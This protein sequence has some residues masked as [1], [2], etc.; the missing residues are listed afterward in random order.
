MIDANPRAVAGSNMP[1]A[2]DAFSMALDDVYGEAKN[3]L[4]GAA[5]ENQAQADA[6]GVIMATARRIRRDADTA[7]AAE[8]QPFDLASKAVQE[9]WRPLLTRADNIVTAAQKPL[10]AF[11]EAEQARQREAAEAARAEVL[12]LQQEAN[13]ARQASA[14]NLAAVEQAEALQKDADRAVKAAGRAEKVKPNVAGMDR[15]VGLRSRQIATVTDHRALLEH[16]MKT[17]PAPLKAWLDEYARKA[18]PS[19]L[20]GVTISNER[21]AA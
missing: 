14:G 4:D 11:L 1:P 3:W 21:R 15:A 7:R 13:E 20:P 10:T 18:L 8:K 6:I 17:D 12:R 9:K 16:V 19:Q 2:I 5:I